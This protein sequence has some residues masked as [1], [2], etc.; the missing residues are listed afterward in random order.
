MIYFISTKQ[1][2][3]QNAKDKMKGEEA[4][5][6]QECICVQM[7]QNANEIKRTN[8]GHVNLYPNERQEYKRVVSSVNHLILLQGS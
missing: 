1:K 7:I 4:L 2:Q 3:A 6:M 8:Q 5:R